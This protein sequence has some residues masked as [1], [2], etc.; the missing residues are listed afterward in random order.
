MRLGAD[1]LAAHLK[2]PLAPLYAVVAADPLL[3]H[4]ALAALR[5]R[6]R[7]EGYDERTVLTS[8]PGF[9]WEALRAAGDSLSLFAARRLVEVRI[10]TGKPGRE[11][12]QALAEYAKRLPADTVTLI[13]LPALD[14]RA[15]KAAWV[16]AIEAAGVL[17]MAEPLPRERLP[18]W[19]AGRLAKNGQHAA[20]ETIEFLAERVEGNLSAAS[21]EVEKLAL[22]FEPGELT[23]EQVSR[24]VLD[25]SRFDLFALGQAM[26]EG[27]RVQLVRMIDGLRAEGSP[28]PLVTWTL[29]QDLRRLVGVHDGLAAGRA[30]AQA[31]REAGVFRDRERSIAGALD[32]I[33]ARRARLALRAVSE[34]DRASKGLGTRDAWELVTELCLRLSAV[35]RGRRAETR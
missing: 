20:D 29:A 12:G 10:P 24:S 15:I 23:F 32:R 1:D 14:W 19:I 30:R 11:G 34:I 21:Q 4:E 26:L 16:L 33:D 2:R 18:G 3:G 22:A 28:L 25:V 8:E 35:P 31:F 9:R 17:V 7:A 27:D 5:A 6:A 13:S